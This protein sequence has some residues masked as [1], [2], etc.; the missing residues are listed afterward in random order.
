MDEKTTSLTT[1]DIA[2]ILCRIN[3]SFCEMYDAPVKARSW[4]T[5]SDEEKQLRANAVQ[6]LFNKI[7]VTEEGNV[8][9]PTPKEMHNEWMKNKIEQGWQLG[10]YEPE[11][12]THPNIC[13]YE[14]LD[15]REQIKDFIFISNVIGIM[16]AVAEKMKS[17]I[18]H[19]TDYFKG[20]HHGL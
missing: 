20:T 3:Y 17:G 19:K 5:I 9:I 6:K 11:N 18:I 1:L 15:V 10:R 2:E 16:H 4:V 12:K 8:I 13:A 7:V 14:E